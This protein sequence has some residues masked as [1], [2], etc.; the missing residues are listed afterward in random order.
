MAVEWDPFADPA[1]EAGEEPPAPAPSSTSAFA[2]AEFVE[3][4]IN[5]GL[6]AGHWIACQI[7]ADGDAPE[8]FHIY[9]P[10]QPPIAESDAL[11]PN[12][13]AWCLRKAVS[14]AN[15]MV[16]AKY[17]PIPRPEAEPEAGPPASLWYEG[18]PVV[19]GRPLRVAVLHGTS[20]N[21]KIMGHQ[22]SR[23]RSACEGRVEFIFLQGKINASSI[24]QNPQYELMSKMFPGQDFFQFAHYAEGNGFDYCNLDEVMSNVQAEMEEQGPI[25]GVLGTGQGSNLCT[26]LAAQAVRGTGVPLSFAVHH[27]GTEAAWTWRY[28]DLFKDALRIP[29]FH[30]VGEQDPFLAGRPVLAHLYSHPEVTTHSGD[31]RPIPRDVKEAGELTARILA[32]MERAAACKAAPE[33]T[34]GAP[35]GAVGA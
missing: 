14:P 16:L 23:L 4:R 11:V 1:D 26:L 12:V 24:A 2:Q 28:P 18:K 3:L 9:I 31:H 17:Y 30:V 8:H 10:A 25:D 29:S 15:P 35:Q 5:E 27:G 20:S 21:A 32:F 19:E 13:P 34:A 22:I 6:H 7:L 33:D